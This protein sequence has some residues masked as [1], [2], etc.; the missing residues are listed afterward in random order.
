MNPFFTDTNI[1]FAIF[2]AILGLVVALFISEGDRLLGPAFLY[3]YGI[4]SVVALLGLPFSFVYGYEKD[5]L[6]MELF[7]ASYSTGSRPNFALVFPNAFFYPWLMSFVYSETGRQPSIIVWINVMLAS[8]SCYFASKIGQKIWGD[9]AGKKTGLFLA[10][11]PYFILVSTATLREAP[12]WFCLSLGGYSAVKTMEKFDFRWWL[13]SIFSLV[14][15]TGFHDAIGFFLLCWII[16]TP[17]AVK[18]AGRHR[19]AGAIGIVS[20]LFALG[21]LYILVGT[22]TGKLAQVLAKVQSG[23]GKQISQLNENS[24]ADAR[25]NYGYLFPVGNA[26]AQVALAPVETLVLF[27]SPTIWMVRSG[28]DVAAFFDGLTYLYLLFAIFAHRKEVWRD[29][30]ARGLLLAF[31][32][33]ALILGLGTQNYGTAIRHRAKLLAILVPIAAIAF[34]NK[35]RES[36]VSAESLE[37]VVG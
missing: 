25:A 17:F 2:L 32:S 29:Y 35:P 12:I 20:L 31:T 22:G 16:Y 11:F 3:A 30:R 34:R 8:F 37:P 27:G 4:R 5:A 23:K 28:A 33:S 14:L 13:L 10:F 7:M 24:N 6:Q 1:G 36:R 26:P 19:L 15:A 9:I 21:A 18:K